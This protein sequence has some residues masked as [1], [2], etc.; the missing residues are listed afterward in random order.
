MLIT[1]DVLASGNLINRE[2]CCVACHHANCRVELEYELWCRGVPHLVGVR[3]CCRV[4]PLVM[5][6]D[7]LLLELLRRM[8][9]EAPAAGGGEPAAGAGATS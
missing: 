2:L 6:N 8:A 4:D 9:K 1:C 7:E 3:V 5:V